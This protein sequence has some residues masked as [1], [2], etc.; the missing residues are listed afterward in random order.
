MRATP[1]D[2]T[3]VG[4]LRNA[5]VDVTSRP[6]ATRTVTDPD[7]GHRYTAARHRDRYAPCRGV[8]SQAS[9]LSRT[10]TKEI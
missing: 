3:P 7:P 8:T 10:I 1:R 5:P 4:P 2:V 9:A 6:R